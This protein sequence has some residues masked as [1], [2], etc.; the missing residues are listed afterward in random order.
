MRSRNPPG[1]LTI[2]RDRRRN[3]SVYDQSRHR[4]PRVAGLHHDISTQAGEAV[5]LFT[6]C[7]PPV[8]CDRAEGQ[9]YGTGEFTDSIAGF[10]PGRMAMMMCEPRQRPWLRSD[11]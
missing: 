8:S 4:A 2:V 5:V 3:D 11:D 9:P 7:R 1:S 10:D 6:L